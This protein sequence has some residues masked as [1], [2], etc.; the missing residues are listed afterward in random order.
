MDILEYSSELML[1][2]R[3]SIKKYICEILIK[4]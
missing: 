3:L 1:V 4:C 2:C